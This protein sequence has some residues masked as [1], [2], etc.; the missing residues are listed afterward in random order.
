MAANVSTQKEEY[1]VT[2]QILDIQ[3]TAHTMHLEG[4]QGGNFEEKRRKKWKPA[5]SS[6]NKFDI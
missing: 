5:E 6:T 4:G 3:V 2:V 1:S